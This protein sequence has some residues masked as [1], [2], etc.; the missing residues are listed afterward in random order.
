MDSIVDLI[1]EIKKRPAMYLGHRKISCLKSFL[2]GWYLRNPKEIRDIEIMGEF[3]D[4]VE[5]KYDMRETHSWDRILMF[6][7]P[8]EFGALELFFKELDD[9]LANSNVK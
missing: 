3:Q 5:K 8:D 1:L 2:D 9:F 6:N 4:W 7:S